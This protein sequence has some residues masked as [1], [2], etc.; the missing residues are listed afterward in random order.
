MTAKTYTV[1]SVEERFF[2]Q[3]DAW[4]ITMDTGT[5]NTIATYLLPKAALQNRAA[6]YGIDPA[7]VETLLDIALHEPYIPDPTDPANHAD[8]A[9][10]KKGLRA[11]AWVSRGS[12]RRGQMVPA[13][14]YNS[15]SIEQAREAHFARIE[16][17]K[18]NRVRVVSPKTA[19][20]LDVI[21]RQYAPDAG[22]VAVVRRQV[23][24]TRQ[25]LRDWRTL[26]MPAN[27]LRSGL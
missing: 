1:T 9:A 17:C 18:A 14:L 20:P 25:R 21:R 15:D 4:L 23:E 19:D 10:A 3:G 11:K 27:P 22:Q 6:E 24:A 7:D 16:H 12:I 8:D 5:P 2:E 26:R 13:W